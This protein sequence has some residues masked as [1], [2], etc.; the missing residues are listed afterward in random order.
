MHYY[1]F[2]PADYTLKTVHL[3]NEHDLAYRRLLDHYY[4]TEAPIPKETQQVSRRLRVGLDVL[5]NVLNEFFVETEDGWRKDRCDEVIAQ[6][7]AKSDIAREN[8]KRGGRPPR[9]KETKRV[10]LANPE[11]TGSEPDRKL[12]KNY[13]PKTKNQEPILLQ[14]E[15]PFQSSEF[16]QLWEDWKS[17]RKEIKKPLSE[18]SQKMQLQEISKMGEQ[19]AMQAIKQS[20][21]NGYQ[22]IFAA[23]NVKQQ[24]HKPATPPPL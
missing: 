14:I 12:T 5:Q 11:E 13:K 1:A 17:Y 6:Y 22:G 21:A 16:S 19:G 10:I 3:D 4:T 18:R 15:L 23:N 2:N 20:I 8:G 9:L 7:H 24:N